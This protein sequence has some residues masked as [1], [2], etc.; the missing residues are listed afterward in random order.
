MAPL[1]ALGSAQAG[2]VVTQVDGAGSSFAAPAIESWIHDVANPPYDL[3]LNYSSTSS[4]DGR[5]E[6]TN[7]TVDFGVSDIPYGYGSTDTQ[8][9]SFPFIYVP[10]AG[11]GIAF[12]YNIPG[13]TAPL[14]LS[15]YSACA[16]LTGGITNWS[17]PTVANDNP[18]VTLPNLAIRPVTE[19]DSSG[20][21]F[22][23]EAWCIDEQPA[24]WAAFA[25][26]ENT[27]AGG[28]TDGVAV[29][30][31]SPNANWP[32]LPNGFDQQST[33]GVAGTVAT[34]AGSIGAVQTD[35]ATSLGF[36]PGTPAHGI[37]SVLN[38]S[39]IYTQPTPVDVASGLAYDTQLPNGTTGYN[40]NGLG[41][42]VY[43]PSTYTYLLIKS[44]GS[45]PAKGA[46]MSGFVNYALTLGQEEAPSF[47][48]A[49]LGLTLEQYGVNE[50]LA[51]VPGAVAVTA[52]EAAAYACG[53]L[54]PTEVAVGQT[55]PTCAG[56][57]PGPVS[58]ITDAPP[59]PFSSGQAIEVRVSANRALTPGT[60]IY[61]EECSAPG[62]TVPTAPDQCD[63]R[64]YQ[65]SPLFAGSGGSVD[66]LDYPVYALPDTT[67]LD[68]AAAGGPAC[69]LTDACMLYV[70]ENPTD[71]SLPHVWSQA[72]YV[73][74]SVGDDGADPGNGLPEVPYVLALPL[75][76]G[77][78]IG[79]TLLVRRRTRAL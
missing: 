43:N 8:A 7:Q 22:A 41:P 71:F 60:G 33:S 47:G 54:T 29:S 69:D 78:M 23:I 59:G 10:I 36:G 70:G 19:S 28:P 48:Y 53:D 14:Q 15:S 11:A 61:I 31:T 74:P 5:Y 44:T 21:N 51:N 35:Y 38:A 73:H 9:P 34:N 37:A 75:L 79:G 42:H 25:D 27:Q 62:G 2:A 46:L 39:G 64:T 3:N 63:A 65:H 58:L 20:T 16:I 52:A 45:D 6:F 13:L 57:G 40:F 17:D 76:V 66:E 26:H 32:G 68:E 1:L 67:V 56:G 49:S 72:F 24:L 18:G 12:M 77:A 50:V 4:G 55:T 30:A